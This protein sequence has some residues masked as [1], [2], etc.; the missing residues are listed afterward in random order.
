MLLFTFAWNGLILGFTS[1]WMVQSV[2]ER[3]R[4]AVAGWI[5][6]LGTFF[7]S[8]FGIYLGRFLRWNSWD[9]VTAPWLLFNDILIMAA[10]PLDHPRTLAVT[11][12][13]AAMLLVALLAPLIDHAVI[14][15]NIRQRSQRHV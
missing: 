3:R 12:L 15:W 8:G 10:N 5:V 9:V 14:A 13:F 6:V 4:G 7:A 2:V 1:L 11:L